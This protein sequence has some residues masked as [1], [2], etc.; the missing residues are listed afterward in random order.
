[1]RISDWSSDVCS[2]D[3]L[4]CVAAPRLAMTEAALQAEIRPGVPNER[5][6]F[7]RT[8]GSRSGT[9]HRNQQGASNLARGD[10]KSVVKGQSVSVLV[11]LGGLRIIKTTHI[12]IHAYPTRLVQTQNSN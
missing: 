2:S 10:R 12:H 8:P 9:C 1:M 3:L 5:A 6:P 11:D 7:H 4:D